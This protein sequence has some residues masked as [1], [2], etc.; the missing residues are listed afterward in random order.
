MSCRI[1]FSP[2]LVRNALRE[3]PASGRAPC[4]FEISAVRVPHSNLDMGRHIRR[5][6]KLT[7]GAA[8]IVNQPRAVRRGNRALDF[9]DLG[10]LWVLLACGGGALRSAARRCAAL[11]CAVQRRG[12]KLTFKH[13]SAYRAKPL[14]WVSVWCPPLPPLSGLFPKRQTRS[15]RTWQSPGWPPGPP[16][17]AC[18]WRRI[19]RAS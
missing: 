12:A 13:F 9:D 6:D 16:P 19:P 14:P 2:I 5:F 10:H 3:N 8:A 11:R 7:P 4:C 15:A 18:R 1:P 17:A